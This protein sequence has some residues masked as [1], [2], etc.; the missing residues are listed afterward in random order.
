MIL[1]KYKLN[2]TDQKKKT[3]YINIECTFT[4]FYITKIIGCNIIYKKIFLIHIYS[5]YKKLIS[6]YIKL[7]Q[8][9]IRHDL[10]SSDI[11]L[12]HSLVL[13]SSNIEFAHFS[14][15]RREVSNFVERLL[16]VSAT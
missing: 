7:R 16:F 3:H 4:P 5:I 8:D 12:D 14:L 15:E 10:D 9:F 1:T 11:S 2:L 13:P 6:I